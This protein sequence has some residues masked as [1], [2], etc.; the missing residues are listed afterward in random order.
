MR[1]ELVTSFSPAGADSYGHR[2]VASIRRHWPHPLTVYVDAPMELGAEMRLT[3][4]IPEWLTTKDALPSER[5]DAPSTGTDKWTRKP[6]SYLWDAKRFAVKPF[7]WHDAAAQIESGIL[8]WLD[9]DTVTHA[10]VPQ[11]FIADLMRDV[12]VAYLGR[13]EMHPENGFVAF[14]LPQALPLVAWCRDVYRLGVFSELTDGWTDCHVLRAGLRA[15]PLRARDLTSRAYS[16]PW[17]SDVDAFALS[18]LGPYVEHLKGS[19][20]KRVAA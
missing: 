8:V 18:P 11:T 13:G 2:C 3:G 20:R 4:N 9:G 12:D 14:R 6:T 15:W 17:R 7:V 10:P 16:G 1:V 5:R 19:Q